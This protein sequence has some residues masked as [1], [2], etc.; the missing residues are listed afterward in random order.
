MLY[1]RFLAQIC[2]T[3]NLPPL[4]H[5]AALHEVARLEREGLLAPASKALLLTFFYGTKTL[6]MRSR[7]E[8]PSLEKC[9]DHPY[10]EFCV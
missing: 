10:T 5:S 9:T 3:R 6:Q 8:P 7:R 2:R 1:A 4:E